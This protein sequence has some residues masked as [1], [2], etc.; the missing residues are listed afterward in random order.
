MDVVTLLQLLQLLLML[1]LHE[2]IIEPARFDRG[3]RVYLQQY[4]QQ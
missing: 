4:E 1:L 2:S 3:A